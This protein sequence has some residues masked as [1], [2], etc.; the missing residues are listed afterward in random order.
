[1]K[2]LQNKCGAGED[3]TIFNLQ[4]NVRLTENCYPS[5]D[6]ITPNDEHILIPGYTVNKKTPDS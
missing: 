3:S 1:M 2:N 6:T 5:K 4:G